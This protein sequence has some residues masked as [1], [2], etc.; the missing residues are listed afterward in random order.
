MGRSLAVGVG[1]MRKAY[2]FSVGEPEG[3][4]LH[5]GHKQNAS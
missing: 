2:T 3:K 1:Y 5:E 4:K